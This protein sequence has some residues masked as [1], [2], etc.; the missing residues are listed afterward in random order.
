[1]PAAVVTGATKG[2]GAAV[3]AALAREG[4]RVIG[5]A[6]SQDDL[7]RAGAVLVA[8]GGEWSAVAV[9][10]ADPVAT[11]AVAD[12]LAAEE[13]DLA[14]LVNNAAGGLG[15]RSLE[16]TS[17]EEHRRVLR[18]N[19]VAPYTLT[20][21]LAPVMAAR[22]GGSIV[23]ISSAVARHRLPPATTSATYAASKGALG[24]LTRQSARLLAGQGVTVSAVLPGD[25]LT[26]AGQEWFDGLSD[27][28]RDA[29]LARVPRG[30]LTTPEEVADVVVGLCRPGSRAV[31]GASIDVNSGAWIS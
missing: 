23:N 11:Q 19:V 15:A 14:V 30:A 18:V 2:I 29:V 17:L 3:A 22:G 4:H 26:A 31:V 1:M 12:R 7:D 13:P 28:E 10:L 16:D 20:R 24:G 9:D 27:E 6:R 5:L 8:A 21:T 25:V